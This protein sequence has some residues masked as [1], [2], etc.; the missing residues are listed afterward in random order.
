MLKFF[1]YAPIYLTGPDPPTR[2][3]AY[4]FRP[5][6]KGFRPSICMI[7]IAKPLLDVMVENGIATHIEE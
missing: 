4:G 3:S 6:P 5:H 1:Q 7:F 2:P